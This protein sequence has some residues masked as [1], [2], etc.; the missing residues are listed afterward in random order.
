MR[1]DILATGSVFLMVIFASCGTETKIATTATPATTTTTTTSPSS[2][3][4]AG[5]RSSKAATVGAKLGLATAGAG[6]G[7]GSFP[8]PTLSKITRAFKGGDGTSDRMLRKAGATAEAGLQSFKASLKSYRDPEVFPCESGTVSVDAAVIDNGKTLKSTLEFAKCVKTE[9]GVSSTSN[10]KMVIIET[11]IEYTGANP[12]D[13]LSFEPDSR[14]IEFLGF[15]VEEMINGAVTSRF[16]GNGTFALSDQANT[17]TGEFVSLFTANGTFSDFAVEAGKT[18]TNEQIVFTNLAETYIFAFNQTLV[19]GVSATLEFSTFIETLNGSVSFKNILDA[20]D[21]FDGTFTDFTV[22]IVD[23]PGFITMAISGKMNAACLGGE[24]TFAT[25]TPLLFAVDESTEGADS[26]GDV[27]DE[28]S[29]ETDEI[30]D[31]IGEDCPI[32]GK[33]TMSNA[34]GKVTIEFLG[35]GGMTISDGKTTESFANCDQADTC[36]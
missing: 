14:S 7:G 33:M 30:S 27:E 2:Q 26:V 23:G 5:S 35:T 34:S 29:E 10:G 36:A 12:A 6:G 15:S 31:E 1:K 4:D 21:N 24:V 18:I 17:T 9:L 22:I 32:A 25:E 8:K 3:N 20:N 13:D 11:D 19:E 16:V 28:L